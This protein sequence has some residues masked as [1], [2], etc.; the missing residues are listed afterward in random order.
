M[1]DL[2]INDNGRLVRQDIISQTQGYNTSERYIPIPTQS[3]LD[4]I[5]EVEPDYKIVGFNN[6]NVRKADKQSFQ[7]HAMMIEFPNA[8][9]SDGTKMNLVL[10]NSSDRSMS[11]RIMAGAI[12]MVCNNGMIWADSIMQEERIRHTNKDWQHTIYDL[13]NNFEKSQI[14][15]KETIEAMQNK[16]MSYSDENRFAERVAEELINPN[17]TG[18]LIDPR[19]LTVAQ[20]PE[21][22]GKNLWHNFNKLQEYLSNGGLDR[23]IEKTEEDEDGQSSLITT[24]SKTHKITN[25]SKRIDLN[26][27]LHTMAME[28]L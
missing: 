11:L 5:K 23:I 16:Y 20:R 2:L 7:K 27:K 6:A 26:K 14:K 3:V 10:F 1:S 8:N 18:S 17:I 21:D 25:E 19:Q 28:M 12:R 15:A 22:T 4:I 13:M 24:I 9:L